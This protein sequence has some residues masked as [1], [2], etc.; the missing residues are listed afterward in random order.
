VAQLAFVFDDQ[1]TLGHFITSLFVPPLNEPPLRTGRQ[2]GVPL[3]PR[4]S[5]SRLN[6]KRGRWCPAP[7]LASEN[8]NVAVTTW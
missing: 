7:L 2:A 5:F 8:R 1:D 6:V 4:V 3:P